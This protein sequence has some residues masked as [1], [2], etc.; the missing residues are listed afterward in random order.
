MDA[1]DDDKWWIDILQNQQLKKELLEAEDVNKKAME[2]YLKGQGVEGTQ[3]MWERVQ[4][5]K[6]LL[7]LEI[8]QDD[9]K[10]LMVTHSRVLQTLSAKSYDMSLKSSYGP[11]ELVGSRYYRNCQIMP[12]KI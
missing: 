3:G 12:Y 10:V 5:L 6:Q 9:K 4:K 1:F 7:K 2:I 11:G 8:P